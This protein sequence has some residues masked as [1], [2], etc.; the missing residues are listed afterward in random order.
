MRDWI[1]KRLRDWFGDGGLLGNKRVFRDTLLATEYN[2]DLNGKLK[3]IPKKE[4]KRSL[5]EEECDICDALALTCGYTGNLMTSGPRKL[6]NENNLAQ[7]MMDA[8]NWDSGT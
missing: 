6:F 1:Y 5:N 2:R 4:I 8:G 3:L 7:M